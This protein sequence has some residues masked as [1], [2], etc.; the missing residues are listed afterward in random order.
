MGQVYNPVAMVR[1]P[2]AGPGRNRRLMADEERELLA[3]CDQ[4]TNPILGWMVR[5]AIYTGMRA[6]KIQTMRR[7]QVD[8][9]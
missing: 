4:A 6:G 9:A 3:A 2:P 1:K 7:N 5:L 8:V